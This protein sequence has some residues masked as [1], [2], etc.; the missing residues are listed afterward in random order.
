M[1]GRVRLKE[2]GLIDEDLPTL[3]ESVYKYLSDH[4]NVV[5]DVVENEQLDLKEGVVI[6][7]EICDR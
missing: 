1:S 6:P 2:D 3:L 4:L 7:N 5:C